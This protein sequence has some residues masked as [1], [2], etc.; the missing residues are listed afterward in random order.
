[1]AKILIID[2]DQ[3]FIDSTS[4]MLQKAGF[5]VSGAGT[6]DEGLSKAQSEKPDLILLDVTLKSPEDGILM[7]KDL[8]NKGIKIPIIL[9]ENV[10]KAATF[11][12]D[13]SDMSIE[14]YAEKPLDADKIVNKI[15]AIINR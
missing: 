9:L 15:N 2:D 8:F 4:Q 12:H 6:P 10:A 14:A 7:G 3:G 1:M 13:T 11:S 5:T